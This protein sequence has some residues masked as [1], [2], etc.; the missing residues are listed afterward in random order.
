MKD[1]KPYR[2]ALDDLIALTGE[3]KE[4]LEKFMRD[5][6]LSANEL[7]DICTIHRVRTMVRRNCAFC[8]KNSI[9][10]VK[11]EL[12]A[13]LVGVSYLDMSPLRRKEGSRGERE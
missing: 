6:K 5:N 10:A 2:K 3:T 12:R 1:T 9:C 13:L 4:F 11:P 7:I 8:E